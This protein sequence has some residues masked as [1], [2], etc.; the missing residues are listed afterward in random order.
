MMRRL[1]WLT[2]GALLGVTGYR[3]LT[4]LARTVAPLGLGGR[5]G[6]RPAGGWAQGGPLRGSWAR[7][8]SLFAGDVR[9]G[10]ELYADR[11]P[12]LAGRTLDVQ[13]ARAQRPQA[14]RPGHDA[15]REHPSIDYAMEGR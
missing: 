12:R 2:V 6:G 14:A 15:G 7:R 3:R 4:R 5:R 13:Q 9:E 11:H 10:M 1:F 8:A